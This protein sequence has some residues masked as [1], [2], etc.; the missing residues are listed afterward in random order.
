MCISSRSCIIHHFCLLVSLHFILFTTTSI[1]QVAPRPSSKPS[2]L[3]FRKVHATWPKPHYST[4]ESI[5]KLSEQNVSNMFTFWHMLVTDNHHRACY[6]R[7]IQYTH[8][9][10]AVC[11]HA[12]CVLYG[13]VS[14][15]MSISGLVLVGYPQKAG[16]FHS[17]VRFQYANS[18][19]YSRLQLPGVAALARHVRKARTFFSKSRNMRQ[20]YAEIGR[21]CIFA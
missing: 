15:T 11:L 20:K 4:N 14:L 18:I 1:G 12:L 10:A 9:S 13:W 8:N 21:D 2:K 6:E 3:N 19:I 7:S 5:R 17:L 16:V